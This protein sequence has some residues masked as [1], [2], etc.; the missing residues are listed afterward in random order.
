[1]S[2]A[3]LESEYYL[4][5]PQSHSTHTLHSRPLT[6]S[7]QLLRKEQLLPGE[8]GPKLTG[9]EGGQQL[10]KEAKHH[11]S[12]SGL[13]TDHPTTL[14][15]DTQLPP[16]TQVR[17]P[18]HSPWERGS[19]P[20]IQGNAFTQTVR[21][22]PFTGAALLTRATLHNGGHAFPTAT[23]TFL[24]SQ[25]ARGARATPLHSPAAVFNPH[26]TWPK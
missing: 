26:A 23:C 1:L 24:N 13:H 8:N 21:P 9:K 7:L 19:L 4:H 25:R 22:L 5:E 15:A 3:F 6:A 20:T 12:N 16:S 11:F 2:N 18:P 17:P 14:R 10:N